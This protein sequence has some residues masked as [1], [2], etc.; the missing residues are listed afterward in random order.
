MKKNLFVLS[1]AALALAACNGNNPTQKSDSTV[2]GSD[3][4]AAQ[5]GDSS[6]DASAGD[7]SAEASSTPATA[8]WSDEQKAEFLKVYS[9]G[10]LPPYLAMTD[11]I[12]EYDAEEETL[13]FMAN[14]GETTLEDLYDA[15]AEAGF[16][17]YVDADDSGA[18]AEVY[19][20]YYDDSYNDHYFDA[21]MD[22]GVF[23]IDFS[24]YE[25]Y[26][27]FPSEYIASNAELTGVP[28]I[29]EFAGADFY[30]PY[31]SFDDYSLSYDIVVECYG[32]NVGA[33]AV[34]SYSATLTGLGWNVDSSYFSEFGEVYADKDGVNLSYYYD[35]ENESFTIYAYYY[36][37]EGEDWTDT[38][39][40]NGTL[41]FDFTDES[42]LYMTDD[43]SAMWAG[44]DVAFIIDQGTSQTTVGNG[45]QFFS[46]PLRLYDGQS[47]EIDA[48]E[49]TIAS[50]DFYVNLTASKSCVDKLTNGVTSA[51]TWNTEG[52]VATLSGIN[53]SDF[54]IDLTEPASNKQVHLNKVIIT[55]AA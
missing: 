37:E 34:D 1:L 28:A 12:L 30:L 29:P 52:S 20:D 6:A 17:L 55:F 23:C 24:F 7:S 53:A 9:D 51:G 41:T 21:Y 45:G 36:E 14:P 32:D 27:S 4:S 15:Y 43:E 10:F 39:I 42:Q 2:P 16:V 25:S 44:S 22:E 38:E 8:M 19:G 26:T 33:G 49:L 54:T 46:N 31:L 13:Y 50:V 40:V 48:G 5:Y 47:I 35:E 18:Y 11:I 3:S